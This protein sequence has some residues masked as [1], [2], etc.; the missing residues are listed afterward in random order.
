MGASRN[1]LEAEEA[2][3]ERHCELPLL[4]MTHEWGRYIDPEFQKWFLAQLKWQKCKFRE[5]DLPDAYADWVES[6]RH[7]HGSDNREMKKNE[8]SRL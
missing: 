5:Y 4:L 2:D 1:V 7:S 3:D 8:T 6:K